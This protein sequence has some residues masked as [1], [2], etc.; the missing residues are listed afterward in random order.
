MDESARMNRPRRTGIAALA[1]ALLPGRRR[2]GGRPPDAGEAERHTP[3]TRFETRDTPPWLILL[4][5]ALAAGLLGL[6]VVALLLIFPDATGK[7]HKA[8]SV[9]M[10]EPALQVDP[11]ADFQRYKAQAMDRLAGFGW[12]DRGR[13]IVH[14]PIADAM[15]RIA[16]RG[17]PDWPADARR[18]ARADAGR[19]GRR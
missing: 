3:A 14:V 18:D 7:E 15:R 8:L 4:L 2:G 16:E 9:P 12:I 5:G 6:V 17:I 13:G 11:P 10:P 1:A 19:E